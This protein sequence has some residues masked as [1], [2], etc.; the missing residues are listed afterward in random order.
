[1]ITFCMSTCQHG[2]QVIVENRVLRKVCRPERDEVTGS[3]EDRMVRSFTS[4]THYQI[5]RTISG[6]QIR[7]NEIGGV[8]SAYGGEE[9]VIEGFGGEI[10]RKEPTRKI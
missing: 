9:R 1:M 7:K 8:C 4:R 5:L 6:D 10:Q 3:G 2:W